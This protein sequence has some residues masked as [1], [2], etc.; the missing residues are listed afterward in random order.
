[1]IWLAIAFGL[2]SGAYI[3]AWFFYIDRAVKRGPKWGE[4]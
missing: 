2:A 3:T 4:D 1:M